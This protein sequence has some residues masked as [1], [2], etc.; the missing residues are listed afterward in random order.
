MAR[1]SQLNCCFSCIYAL[2]FIRIN[3]MKL[4]ATRL[5]IWGSGVRIFPSAPLPASTIS[6]HLAFRPVR[7]RRSGPAAS[8][9]SRRS[10]ETFPAVIND[11]H[12]L[13]RSKPWWHFQESKLPSRHVIFQISGS[14]NGFSQ[15]LPKKFHLPCINPVSRRYR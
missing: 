1:R 11:R 9:S 3:R 5:R 7:D 14:R 10:E 4:L 6:E 12:A 8:T 15:I 13:I 2:N